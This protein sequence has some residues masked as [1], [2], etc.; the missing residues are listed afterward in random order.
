MAIIS[1]VLI[2]IKPLYI[3]N[4]KLPTIGKTYIYKTLGAV[5]LEVMSNGLILLYFFLKTCIAIILKT[6]WN[7]KK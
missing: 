1:A 3:C 2:T 4:K 6:K 7:M 5:V